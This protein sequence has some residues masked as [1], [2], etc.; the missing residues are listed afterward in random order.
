MNGCSRWMTAICHAL[1]AFSFC[2]G[3]ALGAMGR[4][5]C[6]VD[7]GARCACCCGC[8]VAGGF[9]AWGGGFLVSGVL[10]CGCF[11]C[12]LGKG[13]TSPWGTVGSSGSGVVSTFGTGAAREGVRGASEDTAEGGTIGGCGTGWIA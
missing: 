11:S 1:T 5:F 10:G 3:P 4:A 9:F 8:F 7:F 12:G 2:T 13:A 6:V